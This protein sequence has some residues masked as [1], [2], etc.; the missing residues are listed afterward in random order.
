MN[1][2]TM[3]KNRLSESSTQRGLVLLASVAGVTINPLY[4]G[5]ITAIATAL[6]GAIEIYRSEVTAGKSKEQAAIDAVESTIPKS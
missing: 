5:T 1:I 3:I 6:I 4:L 2:L